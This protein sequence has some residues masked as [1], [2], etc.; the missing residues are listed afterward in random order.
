[1]AHLD[2]SRISYGLPGRPLLNNVS[3]WVGEGERV[4]LIGANGAGKSALLKIALGEV[5]PEEGSIAR[6]RGVGV[7][8]QFIEG[9]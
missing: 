8:R 3:L 9:D 4:A 2:L 6:S 7:M 5:E 1:V